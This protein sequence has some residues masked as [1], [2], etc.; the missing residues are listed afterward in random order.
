MSW[1]HWPAELH[2]FFSSPL[3]RQV[4]KSRQCSLNL[5]LHPTAGDQGPKA[6]K[7]CVMFC[8]L[9]CFFPLLPLPLHPPHL[10]ITELRHTFSKSDHVVALYIVSWSILTNEIKYASPGPQCSW[11]LGPVWSWRDVEGRL[12]VKYLLRGETA[13]Y[14]DNLSPNGK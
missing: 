1:P 8:F 2:L 12:V 11:L 3:D 13:T 5:S 9:V 10:S 6:A 7:T 14:G 4:R